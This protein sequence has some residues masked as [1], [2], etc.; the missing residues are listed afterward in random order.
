[1]ICSNLDLEEDEGVYDAMSNL[2][3]D[4]ADCSR[5]ADRAR[6]L[7]DAKCRAAVER[8]KELQ[9]EPG[10]SGGG[11]GVNAMAAGG[12]VESE[13]VYEMGGGDGGGK[14]YVPYL[15]VRLE[16]LVMSLAPEFGEGDESD[17]EGRD[18]AA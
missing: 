16:Y 6:I 2:A 18:I 10:G 15:P 17:G 11:G 4:Y 8:L 13:F 12:G 7:L 14:A 5:E 1:M 9:H 3:A